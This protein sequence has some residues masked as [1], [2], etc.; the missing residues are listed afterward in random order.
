L[1]NFDF[2]FYEYIIENNNNKQINRT[3][4]FRHNDTLPDLPNIL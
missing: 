4:V 2:K 3:F 1:Y